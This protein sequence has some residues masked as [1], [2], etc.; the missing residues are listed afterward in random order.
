MVMTMVTET[1]L[2]VECYS[3]SDNNWEEKDCADRTWENLKVF[4]LSYWTLTSVS[5]QYNTITATVDLL[6][7]FKKVSPVQP[8]TNRSHFYQQ[9]PHGHPV[10]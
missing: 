3:K 7:A 4:Y 5:K 2:Y 9:K 1:V 8:R 6:S 10:Q